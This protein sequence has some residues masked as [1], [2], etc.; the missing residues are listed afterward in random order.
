MKQET[1]IRL[2]QILKKVDDANIFVLIAI[3]TVIIYPFLAI[4]EVCKY[5]VRRVTGKVYDSTSK[6]WISKEEQLKEK[7]ENREISLKVENH[8]PPNKDDRFYFFEKRKLI[9]PYDKLVYVETVY[10]DKL[11]CF[12]EENEEWL[13]TWQKWHGWDIVSYNYEDIKEG[14]LYPEDFA[15]FKHGF[16]WH[17][18]TSSC[19]KDSDIFGNIHYYFEIDPDSATPIKDQMELFMHKI[20]NNIDW[21]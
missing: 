16:L 9:I 8:V 12:F 10:N 13:D 20:Y 21:G 18:P 14:M 6:E 19:D 3:V 2:D 15:V 7:V 11:H 1:L 4:Y 17:S 5:I